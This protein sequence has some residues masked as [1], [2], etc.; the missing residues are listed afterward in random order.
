MLDSEQESKP[1]FINS[2]ETWDQQ[3]HDDIDAILKD[4]D[5]NEEQE[6]NQKLI[7]GVV[8]WND[9][10]YISQPNLISKVNTENNLNGNSP[11]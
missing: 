4:D 10:K 2:S 11:I 3:W 8:K 6:V 5:F 7:E 9:E 1:S